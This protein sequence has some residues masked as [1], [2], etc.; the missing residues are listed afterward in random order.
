MKNVTP[1]PSLHDLS[2]D[3]PG[4]DE[5]T[6]QR[7]RVL[8]AMARMSAEELRELAARAGIYTPDGK[9]TEAYRDPSDGE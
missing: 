3:A 5:P 1:P 6:R 9:L 7:R 4:L 8:A 2:P